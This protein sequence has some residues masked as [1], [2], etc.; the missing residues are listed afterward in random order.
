MVSKLVST[1]DGQ[2]F[3]T[4]STTELI[5]RKYLTFC[6]TY[7]GPISADGLRAST[8]CKRVIKLARGIAGVCRNQAIFVVT[9][10]TTIA[11][12]TAHQASQPVALHRWQYKII[13]PT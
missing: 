9:V 11:L 8:L 7:T 2:M 6:L 5:K 13:S 10:A 4:I 1:V 3:R 12:P